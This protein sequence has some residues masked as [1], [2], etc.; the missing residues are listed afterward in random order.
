VSA[1]DERRPVRHRRERSRLLRPALAG[2][3]GVLVLLLG[4]AIGRALE[5]GPAPTGTRTS[6]R[7]LKPQPLPPAA[8]TVTVTVSNG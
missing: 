8:K 3:L 4:V 2:L 6:V 7:T 5:D 1:S